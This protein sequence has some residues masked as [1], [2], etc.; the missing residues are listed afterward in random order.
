MRAVTFTLDQPAGRH[1]AY[2]MFGADSEFEREQI[3]HL[4]VLADETVVLL[5]RLRGDLD[6]ARRLLGEDTDVLGYSI[7]SEEPQNGLVYIHA[8]PPP[9]MKRFLEIPRTHEVFFNFPIG[10]TS[11]GRLSVEMLGETNDVLREALAEVPPE[12]DATIERIGPYPD[13]GGEIL[14]LLTERQRV[15]LD[16]ALSLGYYDVPRGATHSDIADRL[17]CSVATVGEH[18]QKIESRVFDYIRP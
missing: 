14:A 16:T 1:I 2:R 7:S 6:E 11:D 8:R 17:G 15:V 3:Y 10:S 18:L 5:G 12:L 4:N 9:A 13:A